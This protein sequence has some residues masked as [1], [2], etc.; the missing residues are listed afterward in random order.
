MATPD[1]RDF[2]GLPI[3]TNMTIGDM[4]VVSTLKAVKTD[5]LPDSEFTVP[6]DFKEMKM[7]NL[8]RLPGGG[9]APHPEPVA[10]AGS[11]KS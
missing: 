7:P 11:P 8:G 3:R 6:P 10:P 4:K 1:F 9:K 2:P 5:P